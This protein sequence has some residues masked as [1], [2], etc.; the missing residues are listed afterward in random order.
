MQPTTHQL[1]SCVE[2]WC[3]LSDAEF[4]SSRRSQLCARILQ[5]WFLRLQV[6]PVLRSSNLETNDETAIENT[7]LV[8]IQQS[9]DTLFMAR[10][11]FLNFAL[12][13]DLPLVVSPAALNF[14]L[15]L[16]SGPASRRKTHSLGDFCRFGSTSLWSPVWARWFPGP[17]LRPLLL[18]AILPHLRYKVL[19]DQQPAHL[20]SPTVAFFLK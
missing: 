11:L 18:L 17:Y 3:R 1:D 13:L 5:R 16:R 8:R 15:L 14:P 2:R 19:P 20:R 6:R 4:W 10:F 9:S 12:A 7:Y